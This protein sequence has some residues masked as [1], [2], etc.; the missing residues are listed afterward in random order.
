MVGRAVAD[1]SVWRDNNLTGKYENKDAPT[2][3]G[4]DTR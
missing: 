1:D 4:R 3:W 2:G